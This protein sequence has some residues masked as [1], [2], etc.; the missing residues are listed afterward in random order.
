MTAS[1]AYPA[2]LPG[3]QP[4]VFDP[5]PRRAVSSIDGPL[6]QRARQRDAAGMTSRY[7]YVY[8][9]EQMTIWLD[10]W[11]NDLQYGR[12]WFAHALPGAG[13]LVSPRVVRYLSAQQDLL[14][15]GLY[16][17]TA[18]FEQRGASLLPA[19]QGDPY[20]L[21]VILL[22]A[23]DN[24]AN[25]AT[26]IDSGPAGR[27]VSVTSGTF[28][29]DTTEPKFGV[30][31]I[32]AST[33]FIADFLVP[34][35]PGNPED[36]KFTLDLWYMRTRAQ[37]YI[38]FCYANSVSLLL[39]TPNNSGNYEPAVIASASETIAADDSPLDTMEWYHLEYSYEGTSETDGIW[40]IFVD[41]AKKAE[42]SGPIPAFA[43]S[44]WNMQIGRSGIAGFS[45]L[46][47]Y[48]DMYRLTYGAVRHTSDFSP[49]ADLREYLS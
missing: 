27:S 45:G 18:Q 6:Q 3:P 5:R 16:R 46:G 40:R 1:I 31:S 21:N 26:I 30:G 12:R 10:W 43:G 13:G 33:P 22:L 37:N 9:P 28:T 39:L 8:T 17:V 44:S 24:I 32:W 41:G 42:E 48:I 38:S 29:Q 25:P 11:R 36:A 15:S 2:G 47:G 14:G 20:F 19:E 49:P 7:T 23:G 4:G 35:I 34:P